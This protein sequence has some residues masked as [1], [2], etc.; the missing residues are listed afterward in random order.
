M[1]DAQSKPMAAMS[2][3]MQG[4][5]QAAENSAPQEYQGSL[6][7]KYVDGRGDRSIP[8]DH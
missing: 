7:N 6:Q 2:P 1:T 5:Q 3:Y 8:R 4:R